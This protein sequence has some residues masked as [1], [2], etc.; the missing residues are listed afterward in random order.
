MSPFDVVVRADM[1]HEHGPALRWPNGA[2][3]VSVFDIGLFY[4]AKIRFPEIW[5]RMRFVGVF[6]LHGKGH[7]K[8]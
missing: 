5:Q 1:L 2:V 3:D 6:R 7:K 4:I 8:S